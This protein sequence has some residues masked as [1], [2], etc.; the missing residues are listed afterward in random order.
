MISEQWQAI[1]CLAIDLCGARKRQ[2]QITEI[3]QFFLLLDHSESDSESGGPPGNIG[4]IRY[5]EKSGDRGPLVWP[6]RDNEDGLVLPSDGAM[7]GDHLK[8]KDHGGRH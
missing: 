8:S 6:V 3:G 2:G 1:D 7:V 5:Q 4:K